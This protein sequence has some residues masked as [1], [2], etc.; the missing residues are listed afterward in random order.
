MISEAK[1]YLDHLK[2]NNIATFLGSHAQM[3]YGIIGTRGKKIISF[4]LLCRETQLNPDHINQHNDVYI[5][6]AIQNILIA[7]KIIPDW[8]CRFYIDNSVPP[9]IIDKMSKMGKCEKCYARADTAQQFSVTRPKSRA[10]GPPG[11]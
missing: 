9:D 11:P 10:P 7:K 1:I 2:Q 5:H 3:P 4:S 8:T 6:G